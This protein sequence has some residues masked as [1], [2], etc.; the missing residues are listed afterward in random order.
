MALSYNDNR[1]FTPNGPAGSEL[2]LQTILNN[3]FNGTINAVTD[4]SSAAIWQTTDGSPAAY[5]VAFMKGDAGNF[6]IYSYTTGLEYILMTNPAVKKQTT[7]N[8]DGDG[9]LINGEGD[10]LAS[11][12]GFSFGFFWQDTSVAGK[13]YT[14]DSKNASNSGWGPSGDIRALSYLVKDGTALTGTVATYFAPSG[15]TATGNDDWVMAFEDRGRDIGGDGDFQDAVF[16]VKD[17]NPVPEPGTM[18]LLGA[19]FLG[20]AI[21]GKRRKNA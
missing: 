11:N 21:Y 3:N 9:A 4:Q 16:Y 6:G 7:F 18:L 10:I 15:R 2:S 8:I 12:F 19:G 20:L 1:P 5:A 17:I 14:E 13:S